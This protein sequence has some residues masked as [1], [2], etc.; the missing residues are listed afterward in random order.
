M[1]RSEGF[2][3]NSITINIGNALWSCG[4]SEVAMAGL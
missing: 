3:P 4:G 1:K 2:V